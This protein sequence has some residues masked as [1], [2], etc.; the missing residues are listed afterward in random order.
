MSVNH[1]SLV[2]RIDQDSTTFKL[3]EKICYS[4]TKC[5]AVARPGSQFPRFSSPKFVNRESRKEPASLAAG[6]E[7]PA[8]KH[9]YE[10][11]R[12]YLLWKERKRVYSGII[13]GG[14]TYPTVI[15]G[16]VTECDYSHIC[17]C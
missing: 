14:E 5:T 2:P 16:Q 3:W 7:T 15:N 13:L 6:V 10:R 12:S 1:T 9:K 4:L 11:H 8:Y 17:L